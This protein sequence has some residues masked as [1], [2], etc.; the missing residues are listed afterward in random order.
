MLTPGEFRV[1]KELR[2]GG[3][4][5]EIAVRLGLSPETVKTH[6]ASMLSKL[7]LRD[8]RELAAFQPQEESR[9]RR[10]L[11]A[12]GAPLGASLSMRPLVWAGAG[13]TGAASIAVAGIFIA[14]M[15]ANGDQPFVVPP[16]YDPK[17]GATPSPSTTP[18]P[19]TTAPT[20]TATPTVA[21]PSEFVPHLEQ[22]E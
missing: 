20:P 9:R 2:K 21:R 12:V 15:L 22:R 11:G 3:T 4:N 16:D 14:A 5:A 6:I 10:I 8:R 17:A 19:T 1:L 7:D 18:Q 13:L